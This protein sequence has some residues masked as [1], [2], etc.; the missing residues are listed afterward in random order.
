[1][2]EKAGILRLMPS[3][4]WAVFRPGETPHEITSVLLYGHLAK[5]A[6]VIGPP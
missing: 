1:M 4:R 6:P 5:V 3:G 2:T